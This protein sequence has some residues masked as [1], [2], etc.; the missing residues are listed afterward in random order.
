MLLRGETLN[1]NHNY[2]CFVYRIFLENFNTQL[3]CGT[4]FQARM[5]R[6]KFFVICNQSW[7]SK[8]PLRRSISKRFYISYPF[9]DTHSYVKVPEQRDDI[10]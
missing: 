8:D 4:Y 9:S 3:C 7:K 10:C 6:L 5:I 1:H 2:N